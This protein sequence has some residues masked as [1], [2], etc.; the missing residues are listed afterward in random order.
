MMGKTLAKKP[1]QHNPRRRSTKTNLDARAIN[2]EE[3]VIGDGASNQDALLRSPQ[4]GWTSVDKVET[5]SKVDKTSNSKEKSATIEEKVTNLN[6]H[7][8][9]AILIE[10]E[11]LWG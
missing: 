1:K 5:S 9:K 7:K 6:L 10:D 3:Q 8:G 4:D 11:K 2:V